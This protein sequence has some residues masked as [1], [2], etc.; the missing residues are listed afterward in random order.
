[1]VRLSRPLALCASREVSSRLLLY[2]LMSSLAS[3]RL[4]RPSSWGLFGPGAVLSACDVS[5]DAA[6]KSPLFE[7][8][9]ALA[10]CLIQCWDPSWPPG[11][12]NARLAFP[13]LWSVR[14]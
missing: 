2:L 1:M 8:I 3:R 12:T 4:S 13:C 9:R 10:T 5:L 7:S 14:A 6:A 11:E